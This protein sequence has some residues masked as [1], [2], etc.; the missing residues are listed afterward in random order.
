MTDK[1][2]R[3][4]AIV[5]GGTAGWMAAAS[6][7]NFLENMNVRIR[8]VES[9]QI[10]T[11]GVGEA[12]I[13]PIIDFIRILGIDENDIVRQ[14]KATFKLGIA[15]RDWT[16]PG[17]SYF[18]PFGPTGVGM[19]PISFPAYWLKMFLAGKAARLEQYS[20]Q[21]VAADHGKFMRPVH[22]PNT[23][24]NKI[25]Y[26]LHFDASLFARYLRQYAQA[27][28]VERTEGKV[29]RVTLR[30]G[31]GFIESVVLENGAA[32]EADL[33][34]DCSGF[35]GLL[36]EEALKT[37]YEDWTRWL[38]CD[39]ALAVPS[40]N[41]GPPAPYTR[42]TAR[43]AGWQWRIPLQHRVGNGHVYCSG[44]VSDEAARETLLAKLEGKPL[45]EPLP[46][47]F[48]TGRRK[49]AW[50][51]NCVALGLASGFLEPL[52]ST[53]I[54]LIQRGIAMLLKFFPDRTFEQADIDRYNKIFEFEFGRV[55][56]FL[57][58]HY[59][60]T[61]REG[62]FW[63]HCRNIPLTD[64][65]Q[66]KIDLFR[67]HGRILR[68]DTELFPI[69]SWLFVMIG[70]NIVP[71]GYDPLADSLDM[72]KISANLENTRTIVKQCADAMPMHQ[73][74]ID[75]NCSSGAARVLLNPQPDTALG[76]PIGFTGK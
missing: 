14:T 66:E 67:S 24:L 74:F 56:D 23:P 75:K 15:Y 51:R 55:R 45:A 59:T 44:F 30:P 25:T 34:I 40:E 42:V 64:S 65:L 9:E 3:S 1:R 41:A 12:T 7:V 4:V 50:N 71:R 72:R 19:G 31:D 70:Q 20:M 17:H 73:A 46:L 33:F 60:H 58:L 5:G 16:R 35:R 13:P 57:L 32:I 8:L 69:Q 18:H 22:A 43:D 62:A 53:S 38:P 21:A 28:G 26:A 61:E 52:E 6:L 47:R 2:I 36:I 54:H 11:V 39:R 68:E 49:K 48:T 37:G 29:Q 76:A 27:R 63:E 10:G